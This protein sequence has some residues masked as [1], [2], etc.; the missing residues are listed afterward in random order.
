MKQ[1][2]HGRTL[3]AIKLTRQKGVYQ[4]FPLHDLP[5]YEVEAENISE[6]KQ[7]VE[8]FE[9][10]ALLMEPVLGSGGVVPLSQAFIEQAADLCRANNMLFFVWMKFKQVWA[11]QVNGLLICTQRLTL[12]LFYLRKALVGDYH[13]VGLSLSQS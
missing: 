13:L 8:T 7:I 12:I 6:L 9:P 4:D 3:G 2:F 5:V 11:G 1:S 10:A